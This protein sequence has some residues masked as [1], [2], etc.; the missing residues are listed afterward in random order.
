MIKFPDDFV[1]TKF[2][3]YFWDVSK[4]QLYSIKIGGILRP[5]KFCKGYKGFSNKF[6]FVDVPPGY[7][8]SVNGHKRHI[9]MEYLSTLTK[10]AADEVVDMV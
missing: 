1:K 9:S 4:K 8:V 6:G 3:G 2:P 7:R 5:I 10:P